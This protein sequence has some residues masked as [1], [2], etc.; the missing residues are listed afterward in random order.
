MDKFLSV[1]GPKRL[2][3]KIFLRGLRNANREGRETESITELL[4]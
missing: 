2:D 1:E 4:P 3:H